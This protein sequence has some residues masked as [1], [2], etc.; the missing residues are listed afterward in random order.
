MSTSST[1]KAVS[2]RGVT[3]NASAS[4]AKESSVKIRCGDC[5]HYNGTAHPSMGAPCSTLGIAAGASA[6]DCYTANVAVFRTITPA[7]IQTIAG[8]VSSFTPQQS[9]VMMGLMRNASSLERR[10]F[11]FLQQVYFALGTGESLDSYYRGWVFA[12]GPDRTI[13]VVGQ[14]FVHRG[15]TACSAV[16]SQDSLL[17]WKKFKAIRNRLIA[18]G[19]LE[20]LPPRRKRELS[21][22]DYIPPTLDSQIEELE[23]RA[24]ASPKKQGKRNGVLKQGFSIDQGASSSSSDDGDDL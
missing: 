3:R 11:S 13:Q 12:A 16:L 6:P 2:I 7:T 21:A 14:S 1:T 15:S 8:L 5:M 23:R 22:D 19:A 24:A 10:G 9:R 18:S 4:P 17:T 20:A